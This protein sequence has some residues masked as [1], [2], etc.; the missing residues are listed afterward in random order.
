[1]V[2]R[3]TRSWWVFTKAALWGWRVAMLTAVSWILWLLLQLR[4]IAA[5]ISAELG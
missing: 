1:M 2:K 4:N 3:R 5:C